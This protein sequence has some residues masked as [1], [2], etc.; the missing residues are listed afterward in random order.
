VLAVLD[1]EDTLL[2]L[3]RPLSV[4]LEPDDLLAFLEAEDFVE[5]A[6]ADFPVYVVSF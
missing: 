5:L 2:F 6:P 4:L 3:N 1:L